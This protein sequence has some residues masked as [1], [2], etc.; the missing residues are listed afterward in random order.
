MKSQKEQMCTYIFTIFTLSKHL[1]GHK[2]VCV[3]SAHIMLSK[4]ITQRDDL[5][6][7]FTHL[8]N[9]TIVIQSSE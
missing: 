7:N 4:E 1:T 3:L 2:K 9:I 6:K 8:N 5:S